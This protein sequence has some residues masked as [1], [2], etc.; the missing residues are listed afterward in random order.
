M[1]KQLL[2][3]GVQGTYGLSA[4]LNEG[5]KAGREAAEATGYGELAAQVVDADVNTTDPREDQAQPLFLVPHSRAVSRAPKQFVD[6]Q[7]DVTAAGIEL[8][9]REGFESIEHIKRYTAMG[10]GTD[11][12]KLGNINGMAIA[13]NAMGKEHS[14]N[15]YHHIPPELHPDHHG[16][17]CRP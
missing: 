13:A 8:A 9:V 11:Q 12:G 10:F 1:Q 5:L 15:R 2:A 16:R 6:Y 3:G 7:N 17:L 4:V 14:G